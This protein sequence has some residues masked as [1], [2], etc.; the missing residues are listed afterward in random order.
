MNNSLYMY[1]CVY[2]GQVIKIENPRTRSGFYFK[3]EEQVC[4]TIQLF[5]VG[6]FR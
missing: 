4:E 6:D 3:R 2:K 5:F 1:W